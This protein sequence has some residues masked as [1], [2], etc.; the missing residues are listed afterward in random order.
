M[1]IS[2][3]TINKFNLSLDWGGIPGWI[4]S[5]LNPLLSPLEDFLFGKLIEPLITKV[6]SGLII[7]VYTIPT[8]SI[9]VKD[10]KVIISLT[11]I[12]TK[13]LMAGTRSLLVAYGTPVIS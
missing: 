11:D 12:E 9:P 8:I 13:S 10:K 4:S 7:P 3:L 5:I 1:L 6:L 2:N